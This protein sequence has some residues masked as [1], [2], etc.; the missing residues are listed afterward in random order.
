MNHCPIP[1]LLL[2]LAVARCAASQ[3]VAPLTARAPTPTAAPAA[4]AQPSAP[5]ASST[6]EAALHDQIAELLLRM[7]AAVSAADPQAYLSCVSLTDPC[8]AT[9]QRNWA[10]DLT[11]KAPEHFEATIGDAEVTVAP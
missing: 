11:R 7:T 4:A 10:K 6:P 5:R 2:V 1:R 9:E 8:F 3:T